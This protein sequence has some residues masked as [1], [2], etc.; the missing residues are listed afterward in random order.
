MYKTHENIQQ[1]LFMHHMQIINLVDT[2][3]TE[4]KHASQ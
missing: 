3:L 2:F 1:L 4:D